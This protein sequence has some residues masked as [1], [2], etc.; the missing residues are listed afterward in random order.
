M[1]AEGGREDSLGDRVRLD[2]DGRAIDAHVGETIAAALA[3]AGI[4]EFGERP[5]GGGRG[6]FCGMGV[7][8]DCLVE[9]DGRAS[10]RACMTTVTEAHIVRRQIA[11]RPAAAGTPG[12]PD[13]P[14]A[15]FETPELL[16]IGGGGAGLTAAAVAAEAGAAVV[17]L[18]E[19]HQPGG[20]FFKQPAVTGR[21]RPAPDAR[22][23]AGRRLIDRARRAGVAI[24]S[25]AQVWGAFRPMEIA[26]VVAGGTRRFR[27][28]RL[29][30][31]TGAYERGVPFP[32][33]TL[34]G[35]ITTGAAQTLLRAYGVLPGQR[36]AI[37]G[38]GPLNI[39]VAVE[40]ARA[41]AAIAAV[42]ELAPPPFSPGASLRMALAAP[43]LLA[44]GVRYLVELRAR[45]VPVH[46]GKRVQSVER[47]EGSLV[48][49][50]AAADQAAAG[51]TFRLKSDILCLGYGFLPSNELLRAL[52]CR[53][54]P[55]AD[56][57]HLV[58]RR[59]AD[60]QTSEAGI[61][62][63]GD[64]CGLLGAAGSIE[65]GTIA[66]AAAAASLGHA[67]PAGLLAERD[68]ARRR[69]A[70]QRRLQAGLWRLFKAEP[71]GVSWADS[72]TVLCRCERVRLGEVEEAV[73]AG[74]RTMRAVKL[75]TRLGM[76]PC[77][78]RY[79]TALLASLLRERH[80]ITPDEYGFFAPQAP[81]KPVS[82]AEMVGT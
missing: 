58:V 27:P 37:A 53:H 80:G 13:Y 48:T 15:E 34:P 61:Y 77:Q 12:S 49:A 55:A 79:C 19:R 6:L 39:Q 57:D 50:V 72:G 31:A 65:E 42:V 70:R 44:E 25:N 47:G 14:E 8:Q 36:I 16:V 76:G 18:D 22:A 66:G 4:A 59:D 56:G 9:V 82:I 38:N 67:L 3:A 81:A 68:A 32:G 24:I 78:G 28:E 64:C 41:G 40:L 51:E 46:Y 60:C 69:L 35:V 54:E 62:A 29:V 11:A 20:Q 26:A 33:W 43:A 10:R 23:S 17:L 73:A 2:F 21:G 5:L 63:V 7:C 71:P 75:A 74:H 45:G 1:A 30:V 52:D